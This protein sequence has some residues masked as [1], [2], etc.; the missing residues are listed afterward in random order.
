MSFHVNACQLRYGDGL[1]L[2][3][4]VDHKVHSIVHRTI[5]LGRQNAGG[6]S[7]TIDR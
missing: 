3:L 6:A 5:S 7:K 2:S 4:G 1:H